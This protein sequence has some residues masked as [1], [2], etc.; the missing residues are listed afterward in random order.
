M[1]PGV[2]IL[3]DTMSQFEL[4]NYDSKAE[5]VGYVA[6]KFDLDETSVFYLPVF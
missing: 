5:L 1:H 2:K 3:D 4:T 6:G